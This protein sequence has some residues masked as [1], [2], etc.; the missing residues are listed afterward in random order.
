MLYTRIMALCQRCYHRVKDIRLYVMFYTL[1]HIGIKGLESKTLD[2]T[3][4]FTLLQMLILM[5]LSKTLDITN[6]FTLHGCT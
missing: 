4:T 1:E 2:I 3:N 6:T 5:Q